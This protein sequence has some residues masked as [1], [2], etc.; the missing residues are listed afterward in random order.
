MKENEIKEMKELKKIVN[1]H[2]SH[3]DFKDE[4]EKSMICLEYVEQFS[5]LYK[6][7]IF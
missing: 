5:K 6:F 4:L 2:L 1:K 7:S 3:W